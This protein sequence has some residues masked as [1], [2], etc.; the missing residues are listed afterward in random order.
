MQKPQFETARL[1]A[2]LRAKDPDA[3]S[4]LAGTILPCVIQALLTAL[5]TF[6]ES[7]GKCIADNTAPDGYDPAPDTQRCD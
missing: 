3:E 2:E 7:L 4:A 1:L 5:P 6:I